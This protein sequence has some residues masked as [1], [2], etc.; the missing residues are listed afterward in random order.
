MGFFRR[1]GMRENIASIM[2]TEFEC[3]SNTGRLFIQVG[4]CDPHSPYYTQKSLSKITLNCYYL[5]R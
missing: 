5:T 4:D 1:F 3:Q 2:L